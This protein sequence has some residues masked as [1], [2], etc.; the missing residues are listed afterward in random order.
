MARVKL[1]HYRNLPLV[2]WIAAA[3]RVPRSR[4]SGPVW[5]SGERF[6][7]F[8]KLPQGASDHQVPEM[9]Q[10]LLA[11]RFALVLHRE[12]KQDLVYALFVGRGGPNLKRS[13]PDSGASGGGTIGS[14]QHPPLTMA[15][16]VMHLELK[17]T[18]VGS[19][20]NTLSQFAGRTVVDCTGLAG[21]YEVGLDISMLDFPGISRVAHTNEGDADAPGPSIFAAVERLGL[22]LEQRKLPVEV[23]VIDHIEKAP[24]PN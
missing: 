9:L 23:L 2:D 4:I 12:S 3:Y 21:D 7:M 22:R 20:A 24:T 13:L 6:D 5:M 15:G 17:R 11:E 18:T 14:G 10:S 1:T 19:L 8:A 16:G